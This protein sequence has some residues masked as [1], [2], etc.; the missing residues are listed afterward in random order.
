MNHLF[1]FVRSL[2]RGLRVVLQNFPTMI[3]MK[4]EEFQDAALNCYNREGKLLQKELTQMR[5]SQ[6]LL[7][8]VGLVQLLEE[9]AYCSVI[10]QSSHAFPSEIWSR[11]FEVQSHLQKLGQNW[12]WKETDLRLACTEAPSE[13]VKRLVEES[14]YRPK[15]FQNNVRNYKDLRDAG[16]I[17]DGQTISDLFLDDGESIEPL[18]G[19]CRMSDIAWSD[20]QEVEEEL[21]E[22]AQR[23]VD[24]W[25]EKQ[26]VEELDR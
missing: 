25:K 18:A 22:F 2:L 3:A 23:L 5:D 17:Q 10:S 11:V 21:S 24:M 12:E 20:V 1:R 26:T 13:I 8:L 6:Q 9:Y 15:V 16:L 14:S 7:R 4:A 19:E